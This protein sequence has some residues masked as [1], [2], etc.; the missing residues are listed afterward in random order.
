LFFSG[1]FGYFALKPTQPGVSEARVAKEAAGFLSTSRAKKDIVRKGRI[2]NEARSIAQLQ[3]WMKVRPG[4]PDSRGV[5]GLMKAE[6][7]LRL[8][9]LP[10]LSYDE[11]IQEKLGRSDEVKLIRFALALKLNDFSTSLS[12]AEVSELSTDVDR[13]LRG[14]NVTVFQN[15][16]KLALDTFLGSEF[17]VEREAVRSLLAQ[18]AVENDFARMMIQDLMVREFYQNPNQVFS[19]VAKRYEIAPD[20]PLYGILMRSF[21]RQ[22]ASVNP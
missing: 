21:N 19:D 22:P 6:W 17:E 2:Q 9:R 13:V 14:A 12:P 7:E 10:S 5:Q 3:K 1:A 16:E 4:G 8:S 18:A 11:L 20:H 15:L